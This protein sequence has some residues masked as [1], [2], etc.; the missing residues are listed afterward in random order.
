MKRHASADSQRPLSRSI[1]ISH[2]P[3]LLKT[4]HYRISSRK[5]SK[6]KKR[7]RY[8]GE[9]LERRVAL[10]RARR[11]F[12]RGALMSASVAR[13][14]MRPNTVVSSVKFQARRLM[15]LHGEKL[16]PKDSMYFKKK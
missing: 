3:L 9:E 7:S 2:F 14:A 8:T 11:S 6:R 15:R 13:K 10:F 16:L 5:R 4:F 12:E 1:Q